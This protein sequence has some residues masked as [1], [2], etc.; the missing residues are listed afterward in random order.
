MKAL[1]VDE[2]GHVAER[3]HPALEQEG[4]LVESAAVRGE[5]R[6]LAAESDLDVVV[7]C[8]S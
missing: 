5:A 2:S 1:I 4:Y 3:L 6:W 8:S 7:V